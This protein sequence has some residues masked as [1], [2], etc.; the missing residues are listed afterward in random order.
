MLSIIIPVLNEEDHIRDLLAHLQQQAKQPE[1]LEIIVVDG[2]STDKT[3]A[4]AKSSLRDLPA[5]EVGSRP[6]GEQSDKSSFGESRPTGARRSKTATLR[7]IASDQG[8]AVQMNAGAAIAKGEVLYFLH[9]DSFPP[10]HYDQH[11]FNEIKNGK[12]AGCFR[13]RFDHSH[14]WLRLA[15]WLTRFEHRACRGGDQSQFISKTLFEALGGYDE[16]FTVYEDNDLINKLYA[17]DEF[18]VLPYW[19]TTSARR[20]ETNGIWKLQYHFWTIYVKKFFGA[21]ADELY[22]YYKRKI[23]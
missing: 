7:V 9:A 4:F 19:L 14:W 3:V 21:S 5:I 15:G 20:Y 13:M 22:D 8:R 10:S 17:R 18:K 23:A 2:G 11:I 16:R 6:T 1:R 12:Q